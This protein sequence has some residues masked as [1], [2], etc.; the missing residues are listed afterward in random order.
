MGTKPAGDLTR[1]GNVP[2]AAYP[3]LAVGSYHGVPR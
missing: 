2:P 3:E 1:D